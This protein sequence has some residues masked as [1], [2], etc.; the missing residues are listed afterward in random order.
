MRPLI[1]ALLI[2]GFAGSAQ[3]QAPKAV[4]SLGQ[5][6]TMPQNLHGFDAMRA[7]SGS[8]TERAARRAQFNRHYP[9]TPI[10]RTNPPR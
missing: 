3:A 1:A 10:R 2:A 6:W 7:A 9:G 8:G 4:T 5:G